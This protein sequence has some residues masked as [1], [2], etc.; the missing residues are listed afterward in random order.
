MARKMPEFLWSNSAPWRFGECSR[1]TCKRSQRRL[2]KQLIE[3]ILRCNEITSRSI[4]RRLVS[5]IVKDVFKKRKQFANVQFS[6]N[7]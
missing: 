7:C 5:R 2:V 6:W 1:L 4:P 3:R